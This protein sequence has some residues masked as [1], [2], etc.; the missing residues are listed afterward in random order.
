MEFQA[1]WKL[2]SGRQW[3]M[4]MQPQVQC[5][6][7]CT[8]SHFSRA[9]D[10]MH[11]S[12][13]RDAYCSN[14]FVQRARSVCNKRQRAVQFFYDAVWVLRKPIK[15]QLWSHYSSWIAIRCKSFCC[16]H[17]SIHLHIF[18]LAKRN[19][20]NKSLNIMHKLIAHFCSNF[21]QNKKVPTKSGL[22]YFHHQTRCD[23]FR[24][25]NPKRFHVFQF[26]VLICFSLVTPKFCWAILVKAGLVIK[27]GR[28]FWAV[29]FLQCWLLNLI[30][31]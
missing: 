29:F 11:L 17:K 23:F 1:S 5:E 10:H 22:Q 30:Y 21:W 6:Y 12:R 4:A 15:V 26:I 18:S 31:F 27:Y 24:G 2:I 8:C 16:A 19:K 25:S 28:K 20:W 13:E 14:G 9:R 3:T 7:L